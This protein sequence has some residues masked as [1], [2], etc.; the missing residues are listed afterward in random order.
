MNDQNV[1]IA[2]Q[3]NALFW[4]GHHLP[5]IIHVCVSQCAILL[6]PTLRR[7]RGRAITLDTNYCHV[8]QILLQII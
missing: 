7:E 8:P 2:F 1:S 3:R 4:E 6:Q 5:S